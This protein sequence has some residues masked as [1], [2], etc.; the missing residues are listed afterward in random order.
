VAVGALAR[1]KRFERDLIVLGQCVLGEQARLI[2]ID[3]Y[4]GDDAARLPK[5]E[6]AVSA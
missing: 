1:Q 5:S 2:S 6:Q 4:D 3:G